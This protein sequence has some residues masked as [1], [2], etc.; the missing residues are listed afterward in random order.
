MKYN[1]SIKDQTFEIEIGEVSHGTARVCVN[2]LDYDVRIE[3]CPDLK[4]SAL[5]VSNPVCP[6]PTPR[7]AVTSCSAPFSE[8]Q[9]AAPKIVSGC[10]VI[11]APIP[12]LI[13]EVKV[14]VGDPV[15]AGQTVIIME[16]MKMENRIT[17]LVAGTVTDI[18]VQKGSEVS[19]GSTLLIV[20]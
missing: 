7:P 17:T 11:K 15:N 2:G 1:I 12:G 16:A 9:M 14:K 8:T 19:T 6:S 4:P 13:L 3:S 20:G 5:A 18:L 10:N